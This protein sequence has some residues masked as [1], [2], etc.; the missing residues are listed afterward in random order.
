MSVVVV[1]FTVFL[2]SICGKES[3]LLRCSCAEVCFHMLGSL[4][5]EFLGSFPGAFLKVDLLHGLM[6]LDI[7]VVKFVVLFHWF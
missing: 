4:Y 2:H 6:Q 5:S 3:A 7:A 1:L